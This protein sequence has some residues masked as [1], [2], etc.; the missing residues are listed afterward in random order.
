M[1]NRYRLL[2]LGFAFLPSLLWAQSS[3]TRLN[4]IALSVK[5]LG[6][7]TAFYTQMLSLDTIRQPF[8]DGKHVWFAIGGGAQ[9]HL[10]EGGPL[11]SMV[12]GN[13][14]C[15]SVGSVADFTA[16]LRKAGIGWEDW[17]GKPNTITTRPDGIHQLYIRDPDGYWIEV[18]DDH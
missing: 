16:R 10:I 12:K 14:L 17:P 11:P 3:P 18:N 15:F 8:D 2:F 6:K 9:L 5:E 1:S 13:H 7:S 4:H